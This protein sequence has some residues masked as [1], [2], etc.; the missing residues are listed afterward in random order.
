MCGTNVT[1][2]ALIFS[3]FLFISCFPSYLINRK[4]SKTKFEKIKEVQVLISQ[5]LLKIENNWQ[6]SHIL[7]EQNVREIFYFLPN[8]EQNKIVQLLD[9][10]VSMISVDNKMIAFEIRNSMHNPFIFYQYQQLT[11]IYCNNDAYCSM[12]GVFG[13]DK[14][15][16][17]LENNWFLVLINE[18]NR[19][20][21]C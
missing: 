14:L 6:K 10:E 2:Y 19:F 21:G 5:H 11:L 7:T 18:S 3:V 12:S 1:K 15:L 17:K 9:E 16:K 8:E 13:D 4:V 20:S